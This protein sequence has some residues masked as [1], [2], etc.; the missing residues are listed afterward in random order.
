MS[1]RA[2]N[3]MWTCPYSTHG[4]ECRN[5]GSGGILD[6]QSLSIAISTRCQP[7]AVF[8]P[9]PVSSRY[10]N[11]MYITN[12]S[13]LV[14]CFYQKFTTYMKLCLTWVTIWWWNHSFMTQFGHSISYIFMFSEN[15][16]S[17]DFY[18]TSSWGRVRSTTWKP[19]TLRRASREVCWK[20]IDT[21]TRLRLRPPLSVHHQHCGASSRS[22]SPCTSRATHS[23]CGL[24]TRRTFDPAN[25]RVFC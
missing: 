2:Y 18:C 24:L 5:C 12:Q 20:T 25:G 17:C 22:S 9:V 10:V 3:C 21:T 16:T 14:F 23:N 7:F 15:A 19:L 4:T 8:T 13:I 11:Y 6:D 1:L